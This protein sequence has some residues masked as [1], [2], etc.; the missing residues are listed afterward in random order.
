MHEHFINLVYFHCMDVALNAPSSAPWMPFSTDGCA[1]EGTSGIVAHTV[2]VQ[3]SE[4]RERR[5]LTNFKSTAEWVGAISGS[6][7]FQPCPGPYS[8]FKWEDGEKTGPY[9]DGDFPGC[10]QGKLQDCLAF[11]LPGSRT[12][13]QF[14]PIGLFY[15]I[16]GLF[17]EQSWMYDQGYIDTVELLVPQ[18]LAY[19]NRRSEA[20]V[21]SLG[22][23]EAISQLKPHFDCEKCIFTDPGVDIDDSLEP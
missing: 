18:C 1:E 7:A 22:Y 20:Q 6:A 11:P 2:Y 5:E 19:V 3:H 4:T 16:F 9:V 15:M 17:T 23:N 14:P 12:I 13:L 10:K 8:T 21:S